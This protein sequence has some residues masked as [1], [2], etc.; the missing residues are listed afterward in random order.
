MNSEIMMANI[1]SIAAQAEYATLMNGN[2]Q[3]NPKENT[4]AE[5]ALEELAAYERAHG[6]KHLLK[7]YSDA[8]A[9][10][11][12]GRKTVGKKG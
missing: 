11:R 1:E 10:L 4:R 3:G 8:L 6:N 5:E 7:I 2:R 9:E 12:R